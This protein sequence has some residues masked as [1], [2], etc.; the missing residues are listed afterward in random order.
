MHVESWTFIKQGTPAQVFTF[1]FC[2]VFKNSSFIEHLWWLLL[3]RAKNCDT[4]WIRYETMNPK[5]QGWLNPIWAFLGLLTDDAG[6]KRFHFPKSVTHILQWWNLAQLHLT[7]GKSKKYISQVTHP[8]S[9]A[10]NS[11]CSLEISNCYQEMQ[12]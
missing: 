6:S 8:M 5:I 4:I 10:Y 2:K 1:K 11:I 3:E 12:I 7:W 9:S